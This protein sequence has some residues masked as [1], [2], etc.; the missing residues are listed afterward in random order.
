M[1]ADPAAFVAAVKCAWIAL[2][3]NAVFGVAALSRR[4][5]LKRIDS[6]RLARQACPKLRLRMTFEEAVQV[7]GYASTEE[8]FL[9]NAL[10]RRSE[11]AEEIGLQALCVSLRYARWERERAKKEDAGR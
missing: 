11:V 9:K 3:P 1:P 10:R 5:G 4:F 8:F 6:L 2:R 7:A